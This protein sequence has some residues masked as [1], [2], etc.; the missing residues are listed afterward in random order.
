MH[1][2]GLLEQLTF[3]D[4]YFPCLKTMVVNRRFSHT[5]QALVCG[6]N[7]RSKYPIVDVMDKF[8]T[9]ISRS[10]PYFECI[11]MGKTV[12]RIGMG[13]QFFRRQ[14]DSYPDYWYK[15]FGEP[16]RRCRFEPR[17][18]PNFTIEITDQTLDFKGSL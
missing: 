18:C 12:W 11:A 5:I 17:L 9:R 6:T 3:I 15:E 10:R 13:G 2:Q 4:R 8:L 1:T 14:I 7:L 16:F